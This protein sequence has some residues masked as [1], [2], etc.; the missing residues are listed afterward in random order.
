[1]TGPQ[2]GGVFQ[3]GIE[4]LREAALMSEAV[5]E[6]LIPGD[7]APEIMLQ[8]TDQLT[9]LKDDASVRLREAINDLAI[10]QEM[11]GYEPTVLA[12]DKC[13]AVEIRRFDARE[14][15]LFQ[16]DSLIVIHLGDLGPVIDALR[17]VAD[18]PQA[19]PEAASRL[20]HNRRHVQA[21]GPAW[22]IWGCGPA[23]TVHK[24]TPGEVVIR[25]DESSISIQTD[26]VHDVISALQKWADMKLLLSP[27]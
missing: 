16:G 27:V 2:L 23:L 9:R 8:Y 24:R 15:S 5:A 18:G 21:L 26:R 25:A 10:D 14:V 7:K 3:R 11:D 17:V 4:K 1:M 22:V 6:L 12:Q 13:E 19:H 20:F